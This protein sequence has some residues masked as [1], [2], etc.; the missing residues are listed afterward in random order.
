MP[1]V[2]S[3]VRSAGR[4][5]TFGARGPSLTHRA[6]LTLKVLK[7]SGQ[8]SMYV[9]ECIFILLRRGFI[10]FIRLSKGTQL[11]KKAPPFTFGLILQVI[12]VSSKKENDLPRW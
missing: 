8:F 1:K 9:P 10:S 4:I 3:L 11:S 2:S 5:Q 6:R 7:L 12:K